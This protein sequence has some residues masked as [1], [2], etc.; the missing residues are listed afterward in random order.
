M[1][2][3]QAAETPK[4]SLTQDILH[5]AR[6]YLGGRRGLLIFAGAALAAGL[7]LNWSWLV[8]AGIA[9]ILISALP[10]VAMCVFGLCCMNRGSRKSCSTETSAREPAET[11]T[12]D[13][14][15]TVQAAPLE[16]SATPGA[17]Q[18][19]TAATGPSTIPEPQ[20]LNQK[21]TTDA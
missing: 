2:S 12:G 15:H 11:E 17:G 16:I 18:F 8:A 6:Y 5:V 20:P 21:S 3:P 14:T 19:P 4:T 9:P 13:P 1:T 7:A 10:C